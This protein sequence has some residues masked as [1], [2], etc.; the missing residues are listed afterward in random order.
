M[1]GV[2]VEHSTMKCSTSWMWTPPSD[3]CRVIMTE[4]FSRNW[5]WSRLEKSGWTTYCLASA[6]MTVLFPP[7][8]Y[9]TIYCL[10][11]CLSAFHWGLPRSPHTGTSRCVRGTATRVSGSL[12]WV[13]WRLWKLTTTT[14]SGTTLWPEVRGQI[15]AQSP[16]VLCILQ[17]IQWMLEIVGVNLSGYVY[18][19]LASAPCKLCDHPGLRQLR[20]SL[21]KCM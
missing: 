15:L 5:V 12:R 13:K 4:K 14:T 3:N 1:S 8:S 19:T 2:L 10:H 9:N 7:L 11:V 16:F 21:W 20:E 17:C 6:V 18:S